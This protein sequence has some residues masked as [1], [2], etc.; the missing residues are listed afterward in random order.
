MTM[1]ADAGTETKH[2]LG[3]CAGLCQPINGGM[4]KPLK[5]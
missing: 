1:L 3:G 2:I 4:T 5:D